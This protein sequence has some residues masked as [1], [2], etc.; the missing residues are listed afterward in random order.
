[1]PVIEAIF[2]AYK[3]LQVF[4]IVSQL[5]MDRAIDRGPD[6]A[7]IFMIGTYFV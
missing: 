6:F 3:L 1:L 4:K 7:E 5:L 2:S